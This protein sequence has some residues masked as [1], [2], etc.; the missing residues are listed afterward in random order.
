MKIFLRLANKMRAN[1]A[2]IKSGGWLWYHRYG[3]TGETKV[4]RPGEKEYE[5]NE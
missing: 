4:I 3:E 5:R 1:K 2:E